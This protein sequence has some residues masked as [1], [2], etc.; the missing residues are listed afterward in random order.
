ME[1]IGNLHAPAMLPPGKE[2]PVPTWDSYVKQ[3]LK[4][5]LPSLSV[6]LYKDAL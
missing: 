4:I 1:V 2:P 3:L 6:I 5:S